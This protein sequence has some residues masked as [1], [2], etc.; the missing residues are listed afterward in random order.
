MGLGSG[1]KGPS[2]TIMAA[3]NKPKE[4]KPIMGRAE[5]RPDTIDSIRPL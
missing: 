5:V 2:E 3:D 1:K 4:N